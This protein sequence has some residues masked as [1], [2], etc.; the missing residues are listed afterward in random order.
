MS[1]AT[2]IQRLQNAKAALAVSIE[3][4]GVDVPS[5][6]KL[7]GYAA[8][9]DQIQQGGG[10]TIIV[11]NNYY[12]DSATN[13]IGP[14]GSVLA[15]YTP[16]ELAELTALPSA[17]T[18]NGLTFAGWSMTLEELKDSEPGDVM[19]ARYTVTDDCL[20]ICFEVPANTEVLL[21]T[22]GT[23]AHWDT[24]SGGTW[25]VNWGDGTS[26]SESLGPDTDLY[27][28]QNLKSHT[29][30][31]AGTYLCKITTTAGAM[32]VEY[33]TNVGKA[34]GGVAVL[35]K[36][37]FYVKYMALPRYFTLENCANNVFTYE[38]PVCLF[39][40]MPGGF[41]LVDDRWGADRNY[42]V[43]WAAS[44]YG[45]FQ[46]TN[47]YGITL[48]PNK[49]SANTNAF[50]YSK[51]AAVYSPDGYIP[52]MKG[53][54]FRNALELRTIPPIGKVQG[55]YT[56]GEAETQYN[57]NDAEI[58]ANSFCNNGHLK[59]VVV[60]S[61]ITTIGEDAFR[62]EEAQ[63]KLERVDLPDTITSINGTAFG[64]CTADV[65]LRATTPPTL[66]STG[67]TGDKITWYVPQTAL[68][69]YQNATN[70][71]ALY[72]AGYVVGYNFNE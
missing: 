31:N 22:I 61:G 41:V 72:S 67:L 50:S 37:A 34:G 42:P 49:T 14:D 57:W 19:F 71:S 45:I 69:D 62:C 55:S 68:G 13:V 59:K 6:T 64:R 1:I 60:N 10:D 18:Y 21:G 38:E 15:Q 63:S 58:L 2:Q 56:D 43:Q 17:P 47:I 7:D 33:T 40:T 28:S 3:N 11:N 46:R 12:S 9:V 30:Q 48:R 25:T 44:Q 54:S 27:Q 65:Y 24:V 26:A 39:P 66:S 5:T 29:Y 36:T 52:P 32:A 23:G 51:I 16:E 20:L 4:K 70:W 35:G 8:L 53:S